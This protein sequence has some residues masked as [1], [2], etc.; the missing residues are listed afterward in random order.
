MSFRPPAFGS[1]IAVAESRNLMDFNKLLGNAALCRRHIMHSQ[2]YKSSSGCFP[3][4]PGRHHARAAGPTESNPVVPKVTFNPVSGNISFPEVFSFQDEPGIRVG[5]NYAV[6]LSVQRE[7]PGNILLEVA[8][9]GRLGYHLPQ[10]M[11]LGQSPINFKDPASGQTFA[12]AFDAV[13]TQL[14]GGVGPFLPSGNPNPAFQT[15]PWFE[16]E[17]PGGTLSLAS[18]AGSNFINGNVGSVFRTIDQGRLLAGLPTFNNYLAQG[19]F[20]RSSTGES[21][22]HAMLV[23]LSKRTSKGLTFT[24]NYTLSHSLD[25]LGAIQN[26]A[27][28]MPSSFN[29]NAE[30]GPST[31]DFRHIFNGKW[32]YDIPAKT[33]NPFLKRLVEGWF[34]SGI[35]TA[36]SGQPLTATEGSQV[37]GGTL[38]LG[39]NSGEVP[40]VDPGS[41]NDGV[42]RGVA[43]SNGVG[44]NS[45]TGLNLFGDPFAV[46]QDFR[47]VLLATDGRA[48]RSRP[49]R[50]LGHWS[51]EQFFWE[52]HINH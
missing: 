32:V 46:S 36:I 8:Y 14:R 39:F 30:Y 2:Q 3:R 33:S 47:K 44:T 51:L 13:A 6:D 4:G 20:F 52:E 35:F 15:Q 28:L 11:S 12:Q 19:I 24:G 26:A 29:L 10:S 31:F 27:N 37:W 42:H 23:T 48:G 38:A 40:T 34:N 41:F 25:Q 1:G 50:G 22:Y 45:S 17:S 5:R 21:N 49:F 18:A 16:N 7:F 9:S 43:G